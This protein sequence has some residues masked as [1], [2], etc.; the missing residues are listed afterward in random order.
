MLQRLLGSPPALTVSGHLL[1]ITLR[2]PNA[3]NHPPMMYSRWKDWDGCPVGAPPLFYETLD[4]DATELLWEINREL[5]ATARRI[6]DEHP[7]AD[8]TQV[9]PAY[10]WEIACYG[11]VIGDRTNLMTAVRTN[12][13]YAGIPHPMVPAAGGGFAPDFGHRFLTEDIPYGLAVT[14]GIAEIAGVPTPSIDAVLA[15]GQQRLGKEY[16][17]ASGMA[18]RD[19]ATTRAPQRYGLTTLPEL[20]RCQSTKTPVA[21]PGHAPSPGT[22]R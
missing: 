19:I 8:L 12:A 16:L 21:A 22:P 15:W 1:G 13:G 10:D 20:L 9:V 3:S 17:T 6:M 11:P 5:R 4:E 2:S 7:E 18:G 14:R